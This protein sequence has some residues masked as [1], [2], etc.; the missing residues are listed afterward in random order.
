MS[1]VYGFDALEKTFSNF[2]YKD[3]R[4]IIISAF[5]KATKPTVDQAKAN[6][7]VGATGN[8]R[9][10]IGFVPIRG[11]AGA[12]VGARIKGG[13]R[14]YHGHLVEEGTVERFRKSKDNAS[15]GKMRYSGF[16]RRAMISTE[17][18]VMNTVADEWYKSIE[19]FIVKND[20]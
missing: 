19:K 6:A 7:P 4:N 15:T 18:Q 1:E 12:Y 3:K 13:F 2:A 10:S 8:L 17:Q 11:Q 20:R 14:G 16:W 9:K 5:R